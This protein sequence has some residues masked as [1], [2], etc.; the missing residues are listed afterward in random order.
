MLSGQNVS[1][2]TTGTIVLKPGFTVQKGGNFTAAI[3][4]SHKEITR[5]CASNST[6]GQKSC[7]KYCPPTMF[8][9][10]CRDRGDYFAWN[11]VINAV[12]YYVEIYQK[13]LG[14]ADDR[15]IYGNTG[16]I[17]ANGTVKFWDLKEKLNTSWDVNNFR[18]Y[19]KITDCHGDPHYYGGYFHVKDN[20]LKSN[21]R[22]NDDD[23]LNTVLYDSLMRETWD[24]KCIIHPNPNDGTFTI[25]TNF[26]QSEIE[27]IQVLNTLGQVIYRQT[28]P[29]NSLTIQLP[30]NTKGHCI[31]KIV[32][33]TDVFARKI[34]VQ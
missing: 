18:Y 27:N 31:V 1:F 2:F 16:D 32:T 8:A 26:E 11:D 9:Y 12:E 19:I 14:S 7:G 28:S 3:K 29:V 21:N 5:Y 15:F 6:G 20:C 10:Y 24:E 25:K 30:E 13:K 22:E 33:K 34:V 4:G 17:K 23:F